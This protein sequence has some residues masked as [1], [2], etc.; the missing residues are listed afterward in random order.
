[1]CYSGVP[2]YC[3]VYLATSHTC[4]CLHSTAFSQLGWGNIWNINERD[5]QDKLSKECGKFRDYD[6]GGSKS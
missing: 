4:H 5:E 2:L 3:T 6:E 1:M